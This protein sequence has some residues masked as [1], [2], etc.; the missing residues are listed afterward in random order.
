LIDLVD[1]VQESTQVMLGD[2]G[3]S[4]FQFPGG[5]N[6]QTPRYFGGLTFG[7]CA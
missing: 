4:P 1:V 2:K 7:H 6:L 5:L 3:L